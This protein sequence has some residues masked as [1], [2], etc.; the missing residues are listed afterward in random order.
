[1]LKLKLAG[2]EGDQVFLPDLLMFLS[3]AFVLVLLLLLVLVLLL[4]CCM[5]PSQLLGFI[6]MCLC[7]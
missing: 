7:S 6:C 4:L 3:A 2:A 5:Q 1:V